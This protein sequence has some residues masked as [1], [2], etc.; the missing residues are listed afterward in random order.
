MAIGGGM[1]FYTQN[2]NQQSNN[3]GINTPTQ[4][5]TTVSQTDNATASSSSVAQTQT[6][7]VVSAKSS[8][9]IDCGK[10]GTVTFNQPVGSNKATADSASVKALSCFA[11]AVS[12]CSPAV[13][14]MY[15]FVAI[16]SGNPNPV[17]YK[18]IG[19]DPNNSSLCVMQGPAYW[20]TNNNQNFSQNSSCKIPTA[21]IA[22]FISKYQGQPKWEIGFA[23]PGMILHKTYTDGPYTLQCSALG[24]IS[25]NG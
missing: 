24:A 15:P 5:T 8:S 4:A 7:S 19:K 3:V 20:S 13:V 9:V 6:S 21:F 25:N 2:N 14:M 11:N 1:Y 10:A 23:E 12:S 17:Q 22:A 16:F 18:V